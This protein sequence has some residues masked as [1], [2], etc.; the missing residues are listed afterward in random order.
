MK[1]TN[2]NYYD[3][4]T[5]KEYWSVSQY[6]DF[7]RCEAMAMAKINGEYEFVSTP[8]M[9]IGSYCD[10]EIEGTLDDFK[11][12]HPEIFLKSGDLKADFKKAEKILAKM[13][14]DELFMKY[15]DGEKQK[16]ITF[17]FADAKWKG[18]LDVFHKDLA[19]VDLKVMASF[20][21]LTNYGY[22]IQ[23]ALYQEGIRQETGEELPFYLAVAT[24]EDEPDLDIFHIPQET[25]DF[26]LIGV[27]ENMPR[28]ID[29]KNG[30]VEPTRCGNCEYCRRTKKASVRSFTELY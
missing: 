7:L 2:E 13:K 9:L 17:D 25:L 11:A 18:K 30:K 8:S 28:F 15:L 14:S 22:E 27:K 23:G 12:E 1:I 24:K 6:K 29:V 20:T 16:I 26:T 10:A 21:N 4:E 3:A 19:I 5:N